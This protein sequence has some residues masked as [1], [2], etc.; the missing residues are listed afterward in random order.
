MFTILSGD[1]WSSLMP[2]RRVRHVNVWKKAVSAMLSSED[3][4]HTPAV[5]NLLLVLQYMYNVSFL[6][7]KD[8][9]FFF[10][11]WTLFANSMIMSWLQVNSRVAE[12]QRLPD[13]VFCL[14]LSEAF[15]DE[16]G[17]RWYLRS[18]GEV[19]Q[20]QNR[21]LPKCISSLSVFSQFCKKNWIR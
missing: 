16:D 10:L 15:L 1:W 12:C 5:R 21:K 17:I 3:G 13:S 4:S 8:Y 6:I 18:H 20:N 2:S 9:L 7:I 14:K 11:L 19:N